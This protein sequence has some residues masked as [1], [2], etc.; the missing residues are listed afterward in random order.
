MYLVKKIKELNV[1]SKELKSYKQKGK[2]IGLITGAFDVIHAGHKT[3]MREAKESVD[4]LV[5]GL[6]SDKTISTTKGDNRPINNIS[7]RLENISSISHVDFV[8]PIGQEYKY[9]KQ[10]DLAEIKKIQKQIF[11]KIK[12]D[13]LV[14]PS[15]GDYP[16]V[17]KKKDVEKW[18]AKPLEVSYTPGISS[19]KIIDELGL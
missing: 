2:T 7:Q 6:E 11:M 8:F 5:V 17:E 13:Y 19:T 3:M 18:G 9:E 15:S 12:P 10:G 1:L 4:V 14:I 16:S